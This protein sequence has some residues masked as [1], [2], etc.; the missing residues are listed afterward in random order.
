MVIGVVPARLDSKRLPK[1]ILASLDGKPM[2][3]HT[4][5]RAL[6]AKKLDRV[7]L[8]IDS[9]ETKE[10]LK[11][12]NY[13][14]IMTSKKHLSGTDRVAEVAQVIKEGKIFINIQGDEPLLDPNVIDGLVDK[15]QD[16]SIE[17]ATVVSRKLT[18]SD[19]LN[20]NIVKAILDEKM[21]AVEFKRNIFDLEIGGVYRHVGMYGY[22]RNTLFQFTMLDSSVRELDRS[23]EQMRALDNHIPIRAFITVSDNWAIDTDEDLQKVK[24]LIENSVKEDNESIV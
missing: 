21:N 18:V 23:L 11:D 10:V 14:M 19:L 7:I 24:Q 20:P 9:E 17:M 6:A 8:A 22:R 2:V 4:M 16:N 3:A 1:K 12:F 13:E 5:E 15:F